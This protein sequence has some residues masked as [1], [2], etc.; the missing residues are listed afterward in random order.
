MTFLPDRCPQQGQR[1][2]VGAR[3]V[4]QWACARE[5]C[6]GRSA[7]AGKWKQGDESAAGLS[8]AAVSCQRRLNAI[9]CHN[10]LPTFGFVPNMFVSLYIIMLFAYHSIQFPISRRVNVSN[11]HCG[12]NRKWQIFCVSGCCLTSL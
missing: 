7:R 12:Y 8:G 6:F 2:L 1:W 10:G 9:L 5:A 4:G 11:P 3:L